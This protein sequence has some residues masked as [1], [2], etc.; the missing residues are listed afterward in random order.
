MLLNCL[1]KMFHHFLLLPVK[2]KTFSPTLLATL[3]IISLYFWK[4]CCFNKCFSTCLWV[5]V[6]LIFISLL[7]FFFMFLALFFFLV[8]FG[9]AGGGLLHPQHVEVPRPGTELIHGTTQ[10][11][12]SLTHCAMRSFLCGLF[13]VDLLEI[14]D[15]GKSLFFSLRLSNFSLWADKLRQEI[16][17]Y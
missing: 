9:G 15:I 14:L 2:Y 5:W 6:H 16:S 17:Q 10:A 11:T 8:F 12:A 3:N 13:P 4:S 1:L 7:F